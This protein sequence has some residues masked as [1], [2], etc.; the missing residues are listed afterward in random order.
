MNSNRSRLPYLFILIVG[1]ALG[2]TI[3]AFSLGPSTE[4]QNADGTEADH[5]A[6]Q[7][8]LDNMTMALE[9]KTG[10]AFD[11]EF[12]SQ[13]IAHHE[14][15]VTMA[16]M[17]LRSAQHSEIKTLAEEIIAKQNEEITKMKEWQSAWFQ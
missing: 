7:K 4:T 16:R 10:E 3:A 12:L 13:M 8:T 17:A 9:D 1:I 11:R 2:F 5:A 15:A 6:M 14:G